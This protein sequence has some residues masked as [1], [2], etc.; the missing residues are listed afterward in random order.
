[1]FNNREMS[2]FRSLAEDW[3][4]YTCEI[5]RPSTRSGLNETTGIIGFSNGTLVYSGKCRL[6]VSSQG[7]VS[8]GEQ[9]FYTRFTN[10]YIPHN[11]TMPRTDDE[12]LVVIGGVGTDERKFRVT[13]VVFKTWMPSIEMTIQQIEP[14]KEA[15]AF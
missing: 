14:S 5:R 2:E 9:T 15:G 1:M 12:V 3:M 8:A 7:T 6:T 10:L 13:Q 4:T 11:S